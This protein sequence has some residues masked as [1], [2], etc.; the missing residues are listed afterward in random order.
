MHNFG[1]F[2]NMDYSQYY[3]KNRK[4]DEE[5][6]QEEFSPQ[7]VYIDYPSQTP[8]DKVYDLEVVP[9]DYIIDENF[10]EKDKQNREVRNKK[11]GYERKK[12][13]FVSKVLIFLL[14]IVVVAMST[15]VL[16]DIA[17]KGQLIT[18]FGQMIED[19]N[20]DKTYYFV[21]L[22]RSSDI[23]DARSISASM[24]LQGGAGFVV[25]D[26]EEYAVIGNVF[27][28]KED[29]QRVSN[30]NSNS[31]VIEVKIAKFGY[32]KID[33]TVQTLVENVKDCTIRVLD[34]LID[35]QAGYMDGT[36][37]K[38]EVCTAIE[39]ERIALE[40]TAELFKAQTVKY[41]EDSLVKDILLDMRVAQ[42][43]LLELAD[44]KQALPNMVSNIRYYACQI[45]VNNMQLRQKY[46]K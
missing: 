28:T 43:F 15:F 11:R 36:L 8:S 40:N 25:K 1:I 2:W 21:C 31:S 23:L 44:K 39:R 4:D 42:S 35:I 5:Q 18:V 45:C 6:N 38:A 9:N 34:M 33:K 41:A 12:I 30:K 26:G 16:S 7:I 17:V 22:G 14:T 3:F 37:G 13:G 46:I 24:R 29:A 27:A 19:K 32:K 10:D 20:V